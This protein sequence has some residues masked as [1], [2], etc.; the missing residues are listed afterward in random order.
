MVKDDPFQL[1]RFVD[2]QEL[3]FATALAELHAGRKQTHWMWFIFPQ[4][5]ALGRSPTA[6]FYGIVSLDEARTYLD[7]PLLA[8]RLAQVTDAVLSHRSRSA[9]DIF[10][11]PDD[12]KFR[13]SMTLFDEASNHESLRF[14]ATLK[15]YFGNAPDKRTLELLRR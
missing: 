3:V 5:R 12:L 2:A 9:H 13:S 1:Q 4:L 7:H 11:Y 6:D 8:D 15:S 10:G 14:R